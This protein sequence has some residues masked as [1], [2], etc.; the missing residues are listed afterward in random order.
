MKKTNI[1]QQIS[2]LM[3]LKKHI[4]LINQENIKI[5]NPSNFY[6]EL[7]N[8]TNQRKILL[9]IDDGFL[10]FYDKAWPMLKK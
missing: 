8:N 4:E 9:T 10:S 6:N 5:I 2:E 3:N 7:K 1:P